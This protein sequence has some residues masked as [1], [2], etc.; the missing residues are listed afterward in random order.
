MFIGYFL[1]I[2]LGVILF[3]FMLEDFG[4]RIMFGIGMILLFFI[5]FIICYLFEFI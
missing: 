1:G 5:F 2:V 3:M 4:W